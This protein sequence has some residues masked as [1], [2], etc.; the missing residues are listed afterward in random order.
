MAAQA[1]T[2]IT[3]GAILGAVQTT[4]STFTNTLQAA[5]A[6]VGML[7]KF[8]ADAAHKQDVRSVL[9]NAIFTKTLHQEKAKELTESRIE[10]KAYCKQSADHAS[11]YETSF[12]ELAELMP[13]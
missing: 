11:L 1:S 10:V 3:F 5:N 8:V 13:K 9:D 12:N 4:A 2:R 7:N 6:G